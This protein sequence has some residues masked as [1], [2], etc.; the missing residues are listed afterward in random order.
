MFFAASE[1]S[2]ASLQDPGASSMRGNGLSHRCLRP[3]WSTASETATRAWADFCLM[4]GP[5]QVLKDH[6]R[7]KAL[8]EV[9]RQRCAFLDHTTGAICANDRQ[10]FKQE[11]GPCCMGAKVVWFNL[12]ATSPTSR[13]WT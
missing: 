6:H 2:A 4:Q 11:I 12:Q 10:F 1:M 8:S 9:D 5:S 13:T 7:V 3:P